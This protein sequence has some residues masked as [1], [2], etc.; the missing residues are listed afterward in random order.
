MSSTFQQFSFGENDSN[1]GGKSKPFKAEAGRTYRISFIWWKGLDDGKPDLDTQAPFFVRASTNYIPNVGYIVNKGA[2]YTKLAGGE[3]PRTRIAS[4]IVVWPT[5]K[6]G[7]IDK[8]RLAAGD[9]EVQPWVFSGDKY[10][11]LVQIH[12]E[13]PFSNHDF[14][15]SCSDANF[16][17]M[18]FTPCKDSLLRALMGNPKAETIVR[19]MISKAQMISGNINDHVGREMTIQQIREK[20]AGGGGGGSIG[21][22]GGSSSPTD[23]MV[24]GEI[25]GIVD[26]LLDS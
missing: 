17:K 13:F 9:A 1:L 8:S 11:S 25:D 14:T 4:V 19:D 7:I 5:D 2:E 20:L 21:G 3:A 24:T 22:G 10:K 6:S 15:A 16:Q 12:N 23:T 18:T 26:D